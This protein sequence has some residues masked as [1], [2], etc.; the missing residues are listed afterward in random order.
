MTEK[1]KAARTAVQGLLRADKMKALAVAVL[2][3]STSATGCM[4]KPQAGPCPSQTDDTPCIAASGGESGWLTQ[5]RWPAVQQGAQG[6]DG[7]HLASSRDFVA[8]PQYTQLRQ[9]DSSGS[10]SGGPRYYGGGHYFHVYSS[11]GTSG[12]SGFSS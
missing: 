10:S 8:N 4:S 9:G 7:Q 3:A 11:G 12:G 2:L 6:T 1:E 5:P